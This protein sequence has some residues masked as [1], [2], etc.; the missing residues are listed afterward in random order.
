MAAEKT[1]TM[2]A[3]KRR[4]EKIDLDRAV[5]DPEYRRSLMTHLK[6]QASAGEAGAASPPARSAGERKTPARPRRG[7][8][9]KD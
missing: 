1:P 9:A 7:A 8:L 5:Y 4:M 6:A 2:K 3:G